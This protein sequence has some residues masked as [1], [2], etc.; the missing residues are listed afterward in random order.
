MNQIKTTASTTTSCDSTRESLGLSKGDVLSHP[1]HP[2]LQLLLRL[3]PLAIHRPLSFLS[4]SQLLPT[5]C[6]ALEPTT[7]VTQLGSGTGTM[8]QDAT[9]QPCL[10]HLNTSHQLQD[11]VQHPVAQNYKDCMYC[12]PSQ[13][14]TYNKVLRMF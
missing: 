9:N 12:L 11:F 13:L 3:H 2:A 10:L 1:W 7:G 4:S 5:C 14:H 8:V 6:D